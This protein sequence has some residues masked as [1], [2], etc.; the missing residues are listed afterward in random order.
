MIPSSIFE[1]QNI[2][3]PEEL[4]M[5]LKDFCKEVRGSIRSMFL[6]V[7]RANPSGSLSNEDEKRRVLLEWSCNYFN[8]LTSSNVK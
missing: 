2:Q 4:T 8:R 5:L 1:T 6:Q 3:V 7:I